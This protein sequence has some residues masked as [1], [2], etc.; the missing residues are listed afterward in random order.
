MTTA[1]ASESRITRMVALA[2]LGLLALL[3]SACSGD[4]KDDSGGGDNQQAASDTTAASGTDDTS[5]GDDSSGDCAATEVTFT[6]AGTE[7]F[8]PVATLA[9]SLVEGAA[10]TVYLADF[11]MDEAD[12]S[13][14][15]APTPAEGETLVTVAVTVFNAEED[16]AP[17]EVGTEIP[18]TDEFGVLTFRVTSQTG[19][20][21]AG[22]NTDA[23]GSL[24][25]TAVGDTFCAEID[26]TDGEKSI[27]G[28][29]QAPAKAV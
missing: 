24:T 6:G 12:L 9:A 10:Y 25:V 11:E 7:G 28:T 5:G 13:M 2:T 3:T 29:I 14:F 8:E 21:L 27:K 20:T 1:R 18:Y 17:I 4:D 22:N 15:S 19:E 26:Y 23:T 16:P